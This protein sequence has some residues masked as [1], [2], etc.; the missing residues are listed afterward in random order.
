MAYK[1]RRIRTISKPSAHD[2]VL[3]ALEASL[4]KPDA[5]FSAASTSFYYTTGS[6]LALCG[7]LALMAI[8][9]ADRRRVSDALGYFRG[10]LPRKRVGV[11]RVALLRASRDVLRDR[12][13]VSAL[14]GVAA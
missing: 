6:V 4:P 7:V 5:E 1:P 13:S 2:V 14:P 11:I 8:P 9:E 3:A 12:A 10:L